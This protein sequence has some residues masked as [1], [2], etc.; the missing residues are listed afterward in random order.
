MS[1]AQQQIALIEW[2]DTVRAQYPE[3]QWLIHV[4]NGG[5]RN[6]I[7]ARKFKQMGVRPGVADLFLPVFSVAFGNHWSGLW[8]ELKDGKKRAS[9]DQLRF[10]SFAQDNGYLCALCY[11]WT[12]AKDLLAAYLSG[13]SGE[14][15]ECCTRW[16]IL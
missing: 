15:H 10:L 4:P 8:I 6:P 1:E 3:L 7:E 12:E 13:Q 14:P 5:K 2:A 16:R 11:E 9:I